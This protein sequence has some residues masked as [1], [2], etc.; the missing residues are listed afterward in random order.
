MTKSTAQRYKVYNDRSNYCTAQKIK[1]EWWG[2]WRMFAS[3]NLVMS[4]SGIG[5]LPVRHQAINYTSDDQL[6]VGQ[7]ETHVDC[8]CIKT[9]LIQKM[10]IKISSVQYMYIPCWPDLV[11]FVDSKLII[12]KLIP[13]YHHNISLTQL[14]YSIHLPHGWQKR[15]RVPHILRWKLNLSINLHGDKSVETF[16]WHCLFDSKYVGLMIHLNHFN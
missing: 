14:I 7:S 11:W 3:Q 1:Y 2:W 16:I 9:D 8:F 5:L 12:S 15:I 4:D 13:L 6:S 10:P